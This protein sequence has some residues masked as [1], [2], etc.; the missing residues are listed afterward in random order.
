[1]CFDNDA[2]WYAEVSTIVD[3]EAQHATTCFEC[4]TKIKAGEWRRHIDQ[5]EHDQCQRCEDELGDWWEDGVEPCG[6]GEHDYGQTFTVDVCQGCC[7]LLAAI[8]AV[9][10]DEGCPEYA[11]QPAYGE[12]SEAIRDD[13]LYGES[14]YVTRAVSD[15]PEL[16]NH[17]L[18]L[19]AKGE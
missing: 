16:A 1:M 19:A 9:E 3:G 12:L 11:R 7:Q 15:Q 10:R 18:V 4:G 5:R 2:D 13:V 14:R 6:E 17:P 8:E